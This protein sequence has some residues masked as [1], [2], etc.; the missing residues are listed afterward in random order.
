[1]QGGKLI[2]PGIDFV[3]RAK[4]LVPDPSV[5]EVRVLDGLLQLSQRLHADP[6]VLSV[7]GPVDLGLKPGAYRKLYRNWQGLRTLD[8]ERFGIFLS[9]DGRQALVQVVARDTVVYE[10]IK[11]FARA[12]AAEA[13]PKGLKIAV[14]GQAAFANDLYDVLQRSLPGMISFVVGATF[15]LLALAF[16][17]WLV[18]LKATVL[19]LA[20]VCAGC[21]ALVMI[22]QWGWGKE[23]LGMTEVPGGIPLSVLV[24]IFCVVFGLSMDYEVFLLS[25][26]HEGY[27]ATGDNSRATQEG[28]AATGSVITSAALIMMTVFGGFALAKLVV[29]KML[30]AGLGMAVLVDATIVRILLAPAIMKL[31]GDWNWH[32]GAWRRPPR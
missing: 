26:I 31:A 13:P 1:M 32:P 4:T 19:N 23:L 11:E 8:P 16:R 24:M 20:S 30:G 15:L 2:L 12:L 10:G 5:R 27:L 7:I 9:R 18:P 14:G 21:G 22:F 28:L 17:S 3:E 25:R 6:R 29:V